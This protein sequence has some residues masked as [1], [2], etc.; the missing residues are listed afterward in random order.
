MYPV[1]CWFISLLNQPQHSVF[2]WFTAHQKPDSSSIK[3]GPNRSGYQIFGIQPM[4]WISNHF[5]PYSDTIT[6]LAFNY[7]T[8]L[9]KIWIS[10]FWIARHQIVWILI[11]LY[12]DSHSTNLFSG[13]WWQAS[14]EPSDHVSPPGD[15][16][17]DPWRHKSGFRQ[18]GQHQH[19]WSGQ[20]RQHF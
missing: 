20:C 3:K 2:R 1:A 12:L 14:D 5:V 8:I 15:L 7:W 17:P 9:S 13:C 10:N 16:Q 11:V 18:I 4:I 6:L 19:Q